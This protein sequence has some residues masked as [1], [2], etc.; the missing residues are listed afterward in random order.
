MRRLLRG[1]APWRAH[2]EHFYQQAIQAGRSHARV[3][4]FIMLLDVLLIALAVL[5][6]WVGPWLALA[7]AA[8]ATGCLLA[9][10]RRH[11]DVANP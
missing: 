7:A 1:D 11:G 2:R 6:P 8:G 10:F 4:A 5:V 3:S 9:L